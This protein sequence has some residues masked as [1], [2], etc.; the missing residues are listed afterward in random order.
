MDKNIQDL[1]QSLNN[2]SF[3]DQIENPI[4]NSLIDLLDNNTSIL[5]VDLTEHDAES[6]DPSYK[7]PS[8]T[9][10]TS[11]TG[12]S[13]RSHVTKTAITEETLGGVPK[14]DTPVPVLQK[15][16][17]LNLRENQ[18]LLMAESNDKL[19]ERYSRILPP[20]AEDPKG[21]ETFLRKG[22]SL[23]KMLTNQNAKDIFLNCIKDATTECI[24]HEI[25]LLK[26]WEEV[27]NELKT[28]ILP[29]RTISQLHT[30]L[31]SVTKHPSD[32]I[33][34]FAD[35]IK[36]IMNG[37][38]NA[39]RLSDMTVDDEGWKRIFVLIETQALNTF[40]EGL[41]PQLRNWTIAKDF[42]NL[43]DAVNHARTMEHLDTN[44]SYANTQGW[45]NQFKDLQ[46][47]IPKN[48]PVKECQKCRRL[49]HRTEECFSAN[50]PRINF[51]GIPRDNLPQGNN[52]IRSNFVRPTE[53]KQFTQRP[54]YASRELLCTH[55]GGRNHTKD[56]C[57]K[58]RAAV[59]CT[60]CGKPGHVASNCLSKLTNQPFQSKINHMYYNDIPSLQAQQRYSQERAQIVFNEGGRAPQT[61]EGYFAGQIQ[62]EQNRSND[63]FYSSHSQFQADPWKNMWAP[64]HDTQRNMWAPQ[65]DTQKNIWAPQPDTQ[66]NNWGSQP[67]SN[68]QIMTPLPATMHKNEESHDLLNLTKN[69]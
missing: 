14:T 4:D 32:T 24:Y 59:K 20:F 50:I 16:P 33:A 27:K 21:L 13:L 34:T 68:F 40:I 10:G 46:G 47:A 42:K 44:T 3:I 41:S 9:Q 23:F 65:Q 26:T 22:D 52:P 2:E 51:S 66:K 30:E 61:S 8:S 19:V 63:R 55:C 7:P 6:N 38:K 37:L 56:T 18:I 64:Q 60:F 35:K 5:S 15:Q 53:N 11:S 45:G 67:Q 25:A 69:E 17:V 28:I 36:R 39:H 49:G 1:N 57:F 43:K 31:A 62:P 12:Y 29:R 54:V 58:L 48:R